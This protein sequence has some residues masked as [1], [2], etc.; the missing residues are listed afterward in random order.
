MKAK[1]KVITKVDFGFFVQFENEFEGLLHNKQIPKNKS[2]IINDFIE[3]E[4]FEI[5]FEKQQISLKL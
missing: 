5:D 1:G 3:V 4:I 2:L